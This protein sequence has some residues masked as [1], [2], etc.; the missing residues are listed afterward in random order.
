[1]VLYTEMQVN[2]CWLMMF[3]QLAIY[4]I[5]IETASGLH[6]LAMHV[7]N[8]ANPKSAALN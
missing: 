3:G 4:V 8:G 1:M 7:F 6:T 2:Y 5:N